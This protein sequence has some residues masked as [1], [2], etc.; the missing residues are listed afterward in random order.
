MTRINVVPVEELC[1]QH[2]LAEFRELT[3]IPNC[4]ASGKLKYHYDDRSDRYI[5]GSGHVKFFTNKLG[6][7]KD[8]YDHLYVECRK[9]GFNVKYIF[10]V[11]ELAAKGF[12]F[13]HWDVDNNAMAINRNRI[14]ERMPAKARFTKKE[15]A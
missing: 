4:V 12:K 14:Q 9:R 15:Q 10:P 1:D 7:L 6:W 2:L 3:R 8:R 11:P 5:L 13:E